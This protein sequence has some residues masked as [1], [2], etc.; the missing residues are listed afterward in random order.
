MEKEI[1]EAKI[2]GV[3]RMLELSDCKKILIDSG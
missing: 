1:I 2:E 3:K